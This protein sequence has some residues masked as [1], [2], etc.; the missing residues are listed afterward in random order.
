[1]A[2]NPQLILGSGFL[3]R[4]YRMMSNC[5]QLSCTLSSTAHAWS[6]NTPP[7]YSLL[8]TA[9]P[10]RASARLLAASVPS[11]L[12]MLF[13]LRS[14]SL[15]TLLWCSAA[16][17]PAM[18]SLPVM[19]HLPRSRR[20]SV[21]LP[22]APAPMAAAP[23]SPSELPYSTSSFR[24][25]DPADRLCPRELPPGP[26]IS[27]PSSSRTCRER[28]FL[29]AVASAAAP[30]SPIL[31][32]LR[33]RCV[34]PEE[35]A[36]PSARDAAPALPMSHPRRSNRVN[37]PAFDSML[38]RLLHASPSPIELLDS[39]RR[40]KGTRGFGADITTLPRRP[41]ML[42]LELLTPANELNAPEPSV[43]PVE[44]MKEE[45]MPPNEAL[46]V[47][48]WGPLSPN[49]APSELPERLLT[50]G[51]LPPTGV[52]P[53]AIASASAATPLL[54]ADTSERN[55]SWSPLLLAADRPLAM[56]ATPCPVSLMLRLR[57]RRLRA[58]LRASISPSAAPALGPTQP[59]SCFFKSSL[60]PLHNE[61]SVTL[62]L[63]LRAAA[64]VA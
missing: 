20:L 54:S 49:A 42:P 19:L 63:F 22:R 14:S 38:P 34:I 50:V 24:G 15:S 26:L 60:G 23:V 7:M 33:S 18:P 41:S 62:L 57:S 56:L 53:A 46:A 4:P 2:S 58:V 17:T 31:L 47:M 44:R 27:Q 11:A 36:R 5:L 32:L 61:R 55:S 9:L 52:A 10:C 3:T 40:C 39:T 30:S 59:P 29:S 13:S 8:M 64:R 43:D 16:A 35:A 28:F 37:V 51:L 21:V 12:L 25:A 6:L 1:M 48:P 45:G